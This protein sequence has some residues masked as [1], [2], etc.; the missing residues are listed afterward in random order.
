MAANLKRLTPKQL[1]DLVWFIFS[2]GCVALICV[3]WAVILPLFGSGSG[4]GANVLGLAL[5]Y[6]IAV[7]GGAFGA[8]MMQPDQHRALRWLAWASLLAVLLLGILFAEISAY[9]SG[10]AGGCRLG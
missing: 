9:C 6:V 10:H 5:T 2:L 1:D 3:V 8:T 7:V 4:H